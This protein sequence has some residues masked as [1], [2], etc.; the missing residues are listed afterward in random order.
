MTDMKLVD[1]QPM[2]TLPTGDWEM[3]FYE[4]KTLEGAASVSYGNII[5]MRQKNLNFTAWSRTATFEPS[6]TTT[7]EEPAS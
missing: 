1:P 7:T 6:E 3:V 4:T 2:S 5:N